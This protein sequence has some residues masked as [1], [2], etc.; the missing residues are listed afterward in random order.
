MREKRG[1]LFDVSSGSGIENKTTVSMNSN[2]NNTQHTLTSQDTYE[3]PRKS[4]SFIRPNVE[5]ASKLGKT[6]PNSIPGILQHLS[7]RL[8]V[9]VLH[10]GKC[11]LRRRFLL[12]TYGDLL[13]GFPSLTVTLV[14]IALVSDC[15]NA[16]DQIFIA[17]VGLVRG[18]CVCN[19]SVT[20]E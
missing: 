6:S 1:I 20:L 14:F 4:C 3:S 18:V 10:A 17:D 11:G 16:F 19:T 5:S 8:S 9:S 15:C 7:V 2:T 13:Q 12:Y